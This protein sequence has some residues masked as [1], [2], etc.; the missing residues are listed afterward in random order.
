MMHLANYLIKIAHR[1]LT[2]AEMVLSDAPDRGITVSEIAAMD[3]PVDVNPVTTA[4][5]V[6]RTLRGPLNTPV[7][8][9]NTA[10]FRRRFG[11][12]TSEYT[13][14]P[15]VRDFF[16]H[17]GRRLYIVRVANGAR[18]AMLCVPASGSAL[19]LRAIEPGAAETLRASVDYDAIDD[20][21]SFNLTIQ[22]ID[23]ASGHVLDQEHHRR[24]SIDP[25]S[26]RSVCDLL[27]SS[28]LARSEAPYPTHRPEATAGFGLGREQAYVEHV[29]A[30]SDGTDLSDYDLIGSRTGSTGLFAL[31]GIEDFDLLYLPPAGQGVEAGPAALLAA[32]LYCRERGAM[33]IVDP[34]PDWQGPEDAVAGLRQTG[35]AS[36][37]MLS[38]YPRL[39]D[40]RRRSDRSG[41]PAGAA[42]AGLLCKLD[43]SSGPWDSA[44]RQ[45]LSLR[46]HYRPLVELD[47]EDSVMLERSGLNCLRL[48]STRRL[49]LSGDRTLARGTESLPRYS[50]LRV[51]RLCLA[52]IKMVD[53]ATRWAVFEQP[54]LHLAARVQAQVHAGLCALSTLGA[55]HDDVFDV[56]CRVDP[57]P[58][59]GSHGIDVLLSFTPA[60]SGVP[61]EL[62][63]NQSA[64]GCQ[65]TNTAFAPV[66]R[67]VGPEEDPE[68]RAPAA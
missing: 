63:L 49:R 56:H 66:A 2:D 37:N 65:V 13:L 38:Y 32:E 33:L 57:S 59:A 62:R 45:A 7:L 4:A 20:Q 42:L 54:G 29:Q 55:F 18:G 9:E 60:S 51:R 30:G 1:N 8:V 28:E 25:Q 26:D 22:R 68:V 61:L 24:V 58:A 15:A 17:G 40:L 12:T 39:R 52:L 41:L 21:A 10:E 16:E 50:D 35:Y 53:R 11:D 36:P 34:P 67:R 3:Q 48:D 5:F 64:A 43:E 47:D 14:G 31:D 23:S 27:L 6:G 44:D 19:V 46:R